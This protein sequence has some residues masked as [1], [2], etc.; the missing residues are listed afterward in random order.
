[1]SASEDHCAVLHEQC[2][3][4]VSWIRPRRKT[5]STMDERNN[6]N[7]LKPSQIPKLLPV[8]V[9]IV[10]QGVLFHYFYGPLF[11]SAKI[12]QLPLL[13]INEITGNCRCP[14]P[15]CERNIKILKFWFWYLVQAP[16][17][18]TMELHPAKQCYNT[19]TK[20]QQPCSTWFKLSLNS[21]ATRGK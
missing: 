14:T 18:N 19:G 20:A 8:C 11:T 7:A 4:L 9:N 13:S 17:L 5:F 2:H 21:A 1:M 15:I 10:V 16:G 6:K 12:N 3:L